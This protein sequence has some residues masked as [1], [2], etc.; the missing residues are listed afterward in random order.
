VE[1]PADSK[2]FI[3]RQYSWV[4][5]EPISSG[6][7]NNP[8]GADRSGPCRTFYEPVTGNPCCKKPRVETPAAFLA[9]L[10]PMPQQSNPQG[11][12]PSVRIR[13][14]SRFPPT[15][16]WTSPAGIG[17]EVLRGAGCFAV[18]DE[19]SVCLARLRTPNCAT[20][21]C[22]QLA[23]DRATFSVLP[24]GSFSWLSSFTRRLRAMNSPNAR[25]GGLSAF[26]AALFA[27]CVLGSKT[28]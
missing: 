11:T 6:P 2:Q 26:W 16:R 20:L 27:S 22:K 5:N 3:A 18:A 12:R 7:A 24:L 4:G 23:C 25:F 14:K 8:G 10:L 28:G 9:A 21:I 17:R 13:R 1:W 19:I 15:E